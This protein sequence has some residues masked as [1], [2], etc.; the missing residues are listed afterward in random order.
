MGKEPLNGFEI[1]AIMSLVKKGY[2][3]LEVNYET[4]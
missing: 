3:K 1:K 2:L 4:T